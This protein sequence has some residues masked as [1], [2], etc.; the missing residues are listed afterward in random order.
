MAKPKYPY[1]LDFT[2]TRVDANGEH[3][4]PD[5][6]MSL[7]QAKREIE[8]I[9]TEG[10]DFWQSFKDFWSILFGFIFHIEMYSSD[11]TTARRGMVY[12][13]THELAAQR[14]IAAAQAAEA[15]A[16]DEQRMRYLAR[17]I[18]EEMDQRRGY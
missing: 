17:A 4:L 7:E 14:Q 2:G 16:R 10:H 11:P 8:G 6:G 15:E 9:A 13:A 1:T 18:A 12:T 5:A 3:W